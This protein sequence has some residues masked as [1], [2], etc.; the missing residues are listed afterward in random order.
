MR[1]ALL[2]I[3]LVSI[4]WAQTEERVWDWH[5][6]G[7]AGQGYHQP[8]EA[9]DIWAR[10]FHTLR[11]TGDTLW[12]LG[13]VCIPD[14]QEVYLPSPTGPIRIEIP[15]VSYRREASFIAL[16]DRTEGTFW[17]LSWRMPKRARS[18][19]CALWTLCSPIIA[20]PF[21]LQ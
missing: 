5:G 12:V 16:Y 17:G 9:S 13:R 7:D 18:M 11:L 14:N 20:T 4:V 1:E 8:G 2:G 6:E 10:R 21:G 3:G 15:S 19:E